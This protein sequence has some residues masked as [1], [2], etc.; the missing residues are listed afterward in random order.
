M[1]SGG[2]RI[3]K[4]NKRS[5]ENSPLITIITVVRNGEQIIEETIASVLQQEY[6]NIEY[7]I[8]DGGSTDNTIEKIKKHE[9]SIDLWI[10]EPDKGIYD[11]MNKGIALAS[12]EWI[13]FMNAGDQ[14]YDFSTLKKIVSEIIKKKSDIIY[15]DFIAVNEDSKDE[16]YI[17]S[18]SLSEIWKGMIFCH[19]SVFIKRNL[20]LQ[21]PFDIKFK[22]VADYKQILSLYC[23]GYD[24]KNLEM[25]ISKISIDGVSYSNNKTIIETIKVIY[26]IRPKSLSI[27]YFIMQFLK[28]FLRIIIG[29]KLTNLIRK[30]KWKLIMA[31]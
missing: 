3:N 1:K 21:I 29:R 14:F 26:T 5:I 16:V 17:K 30:Y 27:F 25:P 2:L 28:S 11:A 15:G 20:L 9:N 12:G 22:I 10:S 6:N 19:Q 23:D 4:I 13:N 7:I 8:I 18:K 24:F 31:N